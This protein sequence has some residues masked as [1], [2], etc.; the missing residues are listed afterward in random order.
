MRARPGPRRSRVVSAVV[1]A[2]WSEGGGVPVAGADP[3]D[4]LDRAD[5]DLPVADP[6]GLRRRHDDADHVEGVAVLDHDLDPD[7]GDERDVVLGTAVD[8]GV[9]LLPAVAADLADGHPGDPEGLERLADVLPLVRLDDRCHELHARTPVPPAR[10]YADS[11]CWS[12][13]IP[14]T[15][16]S[17]VT[18]QPIVTLMAIAMPAVRT[19]VHTMVNVA[20]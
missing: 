11:P 15:S 16:A 5:P 12:P 13:S 14:S 19:P 6:A 3:H 10:S 2:Q 17:S 4:A 9:A 20:A 1:R 8:L 7:L 18:R